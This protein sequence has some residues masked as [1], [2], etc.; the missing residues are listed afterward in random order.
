MSRRE[1]ELMIA[2]QA[3][4]EHALENIYTL[5]KPAVYSFVFRYTREEQLSIDIVQDTFVKLQQFKDNYQADKGNLK[6]YLFQIAYRLMVTKLNRRKKLQSFLPFLV[7]IATGG[8]EP[9]DRMTIQKAVANL[10]DLQRAVIL[11]YYYHDIPQS[12]IATILDIPKGTVK[13]R[14]HSAIQRLK[15]DL[16]GD[17]YD[18]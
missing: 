14:I 9:S 10:P 1:D 11:L 7:P 4:D 3:G 15:E 2:Y 8:L 18:S 17:F 5:L 12:E 16:G 13:S 6:A